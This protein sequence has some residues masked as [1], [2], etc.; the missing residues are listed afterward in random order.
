MVEEK[1]V[2]IGKVYRRVLVVGVYDSCRSR[3]GIVRR[4]LFCI[5]VGSE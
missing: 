3:V 5:K 1:N 2:F 4:C